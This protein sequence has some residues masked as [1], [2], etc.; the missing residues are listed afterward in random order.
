MNL[1]EGSWPRFRQSVTIALHITPMIASAT[2]STPIAFRRS[3]HVHLHFVRLKLFSRTQIDR[4]TLRF[5]RHVEEVRQVTHRD[6]AGEWYARATDRATACRT[7][8]E[9]SKAVHGFL[10]RE[11]TF[12]RRPKC[13]VKTPRPDGRE[14]RAIVARGTSLK[15]RA[16]FL[17]E[18][19]QLSDHQDAGSYGMEVDPTS[20]D[21]LAATLSPLAGVIATRRGRCWRRAAMPGA[22]LAGTTGRRGR[23]RAG[24]AG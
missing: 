16:A 6:R 9:F 23:L 22:T 2:A 15:A 8:R 10:E 5:D 13:A 4:R 20:E 21:E 7:E 1:R 19:S 14:V 11:N 12:V 18:A 3:S 24:G 17:I